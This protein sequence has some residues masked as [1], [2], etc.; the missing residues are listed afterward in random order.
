MVTSPTSW[1]S[2]PTEPQQ[3]SSTS[4][5]ST[6]STETRSTLPTDFTKR[7]PDGRFVHDDPF[8]EKNGLSITGLHIDHDSH[9]SVQTYMS[10]V[11]SD[12]DRTGE[13]EEVDD[14]DDDGDS[15]DED[16]E[17][18]TDSDD[19]FQMVSME[20]RQFVPQ[21]IAS[22]PNDFA[23]FFPSS[24]R[25]SICHDD[26]TIDGNMN[27]RLDILVDTV[28]GK[29]RP[30]TLFHL[31]MHDLKSRDFSLRR[32]CRDSG[33]EVCRSSRKYHESSD[34]QSPSL[35]RSLSSA[36]ATLMRHNSALY[37]I[38]KSPVLGRTNSDFSNYHDKAD[39][40]LPRESR[41][42]ELKHPTNKIK[43][44]FSNYAQVEIK[45][46]GPT[47]QKRYDFFYWGCKYS[48]RR[49]VKPY[50]DDSDVTYH[51][52]KQGSKLPSAHIVPTP[53][54]NWEM[55]E[56]ERKGGW[57]PPSSFWIK[58]PELSSHPDIAE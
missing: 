8:D 43:L 1:T 34:G 33:R 54:T 55:D 45:R 29:K 49:V 24:T 40:V 25:I 5:A 28:S 20:R 6:H 31:R 2:S 30:L 26:A 47:S 13:S 58:D 21:P 46:H 7:I 44:E 9:V 17:S 37:R 39:S 56:E 36:W 57:V 50:G 23:H 19:S 42:R 11:P 41:N 52:L 32:Y 4:A 18:D 15:D 51:L 16:G 27:L 48:W 14:E 38:P 3:G 12:I 53:Q 35:Q 22:T 10:T